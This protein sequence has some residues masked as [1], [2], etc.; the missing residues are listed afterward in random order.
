LENGCDT[1]LL[2]GYVLGHVPM[3]AK[4]LVKRFG[5]SGPTPGQETGDKL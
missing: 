4:S 2:N 1:K 3:V 5:V